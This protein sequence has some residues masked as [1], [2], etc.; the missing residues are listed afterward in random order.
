[1]QYHE[2]LRKLGKNNVAAFIKKYEWVGVHMFLGDPLDAEKVEKEVSGVSKRRETPKEKN[3]PDSYKKI[4]DVGSK[5]AFYRSYLVETADRVAYR[6]IPLIKE[7]A[8]KNNLKWE[9]MLL[10]TF[11]EIINLQIKEKSYFAKK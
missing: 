5:L 11:E 9:D 2:E 8:K 10:L 3:L 7:L 4:I 1:M 6:H